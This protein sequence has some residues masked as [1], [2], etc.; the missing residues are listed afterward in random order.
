MYSK[1][2]FETCQTRRLTEVAEGPGG[3]VIRVAVVKMYGNIRGD[4]TKYAD[5]FARNIWIMLKTSD[6]S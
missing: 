2:H 6:K 3:G 5:E 4:L 1:Y